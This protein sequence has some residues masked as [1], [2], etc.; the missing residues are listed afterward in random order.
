MIIAIIASAIPVLAFSSGS[1]SG[2]IIVV[3]A[4]QPRKVP[5]CLVVPAD[6]V[7]VPIR[8][9]TDQKNSALAYEE[10]RQ[11]IE[12]ISQK[13]QANGQFRISAAVVTLAPEEN[14]GSAPDIGH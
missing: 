10:I 14:E 1:I 11:A 7:A 9:V 6:Y 2:P 3:A 12:L 13:A 5:V 8:I 4:T